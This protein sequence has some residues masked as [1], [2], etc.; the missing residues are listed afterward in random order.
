MKKIL[1]LAIAAAFLA[2]G[3]AG[4][5]VVPTRTAPTKFIV[6]SDCR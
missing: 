1:L 3:C 5:Q 2:A 6:E 4:T